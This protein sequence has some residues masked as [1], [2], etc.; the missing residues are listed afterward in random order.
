AKGKARDALDQLDGKND[1]IGPGSAKTHGDPLHPDGSDPGNGTGPGTGTDKP[2]AK[3]ESGSGSGSGS[4]KPSPS[5]P[6]P[7]SGS[8]SGSSTKNPSSS[9]SSK[10]NAT[11][12]VRT[13]TYAAS[14]RK[15]D[16]FGTPSI[17]DPLFAAKADVVV[18][19]DLAKVT[20]YVVDPIPNYTD[21]GTPLSRVKFVYQGKAYSAA[22]QS[23][24]KVKRQFGTSA[25]FI[26]TAGTYPATPITVTLP[27]AALEASKS[28]GL[29]C[30]AHVNAVLDADQEFYL[31]LCNAKLIS[32]KT[33]RTGSSSSTLKKSSSG[34][35]TTLRT[36]AT[37][38]SGS[39]STLSSESADDAAEDES[40]DRST[41]R[42]A[43]AAESGDQGGI[44]SR[45][46]GTAHGSYSHPTTGEVADSAGPVGQAM[47]SAMIGK[48]IDPQCLLEEGTDGTWLSL[49]WHLTNAISDVV[50]QTQ[51]PGQDSWTDVDYELT[52]ESDDSFDLRLPVQ[53][54]QT[55]IKAQCLI[56]PI[57]RT[58]TFFI[59]ADEWTDGN[60]GG[61]AQLPDATDSGESAAPTPAPA[62]AAPAWQPTL[63]FWATLVAAVFGS[64]FLGVLAALRL[65]RRLEHKRSA[66]DAAG[67]GP[68]PE[69]ADIPA[70]APG[71]QA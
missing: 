60:A 49:R 63:G 22:Y 16:A 36:S 43:G 2:A 67:P 46:S 53:S 21:E 66:A 38:G 55:V 32:T 12:T 10:K 59:Y 41:S 17:C 25:M 71:S 61:F 51:E 29:K 68:E 62:A 20:V 54:D 4:Q 48:V 50:L 31:V 28:G 40:A 56:K 57:G 64:A 58:V 52:A 24:S 9:S 42:K 39:V 27:K 18:S 35:A 13:Y 65:N 70:D 3:P 14:F 6:K 37:S 7:S 23:S 69:P 44:T 45:R 33:V 5:K 26:S 19:G 8:S 30:Q 1:D 34:T 15:A 47:G 11:T